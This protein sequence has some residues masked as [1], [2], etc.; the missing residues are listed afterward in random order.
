[1]G[2]SST[3]KIWYPSSPA[4]VRLL[5]VAHVHAESG[6]DVVISFTIAIQ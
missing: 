1:M 2:W 3:Y 4:L 5:V 6:P